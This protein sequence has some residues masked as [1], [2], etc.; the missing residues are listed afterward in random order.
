MVELRQYLAQTL[1]WTVA[2]VLSSP[3]EIRNS[4]IGKTLLRGEPG[5]MLPRQETTH[6]IAN[7]TLINLLFDLCGQ[8]ERKAK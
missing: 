7:V 2:Y 5:L 6:S 1:D 4:G 3:D 8:R